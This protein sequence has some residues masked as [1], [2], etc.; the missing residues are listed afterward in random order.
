[1]AFELGFLELD[2]AR[3]YIVL[4]RPHYVMIAVVCALSSDMFYDIYELLHFKNP[5]FI[6]NNLLSFLHCQKSDCENAISSMERPVLGS[7]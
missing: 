2:P 7:Q 6:K 4:G 5:V 3:V 1:V